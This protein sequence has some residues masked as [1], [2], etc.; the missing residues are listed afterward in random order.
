MTATCGTCHPE[1]AATYLSNIHG[2]MGVHLK[3]P[4]SAF[5]TDCH[6]AHNVV[7]LSDKAQA[8]AVCRR[9]HPKADARFA[10]VVIHDGMDRPASADAAKNQ[11][12]LWID[13]VRTA[14]IAIVALS[15][16]FFFGH[17]FLWLL[18]EVHEKLRKH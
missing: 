18:R 16:V 8:L 13:R 10:D 11:S 5:C 7:S 9:C 17:S 1:H 6:G 12:V 15:L 4:D 3:N 2:K 14:A